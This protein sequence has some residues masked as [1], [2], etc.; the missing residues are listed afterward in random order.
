MHNHLNRI[1]D[2]VRHGPG[3]VLGDFIV[4]GEAP[5]GADCG[6]LTLGAHCTLRS[7][8]V[9]YA[10]N[11]IGDALQTGHHVLIREL[12]TLGDRVSI[13]SSSIVEH[14]VTIG[15]RVRIHSGVFVPEFTILEDGCWLGPRVTI[16][17][18]PYPSA[19]RTK[20]FLAGVRIGR[21]AKIG[22]NATLLPGVTI[23]RGALVGAGAVVTRDVPE[24]AVVVGNPARAIGNIFDLKHPDG[25]AAYFKED[26]QD[27]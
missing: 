16:T 11:Q 26:F 8:T 22:A 5:A 13:G 25:Q 18:A 2:C 6:L 4:L 9:I 10:G 21:G 3:L 14:H 15:D 12:N 7:H 23:G 1:Y 24:Y 20:D 27:A 19:R 17:N